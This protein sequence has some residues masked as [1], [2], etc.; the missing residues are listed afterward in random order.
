MEDRE[1][2]DYLYQGWAK[3]TGAEGMFW[4]PEKD[5]CYDEEGIDASLH[6]IVAVDKDQN[7][8]HVAQYLTEADAAFVTAVHGCFGDLTRRLHSAID[9]AERLDEQRDDQEFRIAELAMENEELRERIVQ[10]EDG[11]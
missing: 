9:E 1:F 3:T 2:I 7:K 4:M 5:D 11:L 8:V 10:L 6:S